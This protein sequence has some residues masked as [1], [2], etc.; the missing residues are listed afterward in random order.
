MIIR[1]DVRTNSQRLS[2]SSPRANRMSGRSSQVRPYGPSVRPKANCG[3]DARPGRNAGEQDQAQ[4]QR[5]QRRRQRDRARRP[6]CRAGA[7]AKRTRLPSQREQ[8][9]DHQQ[10]RHR[11]VLV[12]RSTLDRHAPVTRSVADQ[13]QQQ[14]PEQARHA[15]RGDRRVELDQ[16]VLERRQHLAADEPGHPGRQ[17]DEAV[18]QVVVEERADASPAPGAAG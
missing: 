18:H 7:T 4:R 8:D 6:V 9:R 2:P 17:P 10:G 15:Q 1:S 12:A 3:V 5:R 16:A 14:D 13:H 11:R